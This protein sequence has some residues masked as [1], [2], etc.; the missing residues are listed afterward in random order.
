MF[1]LESDENGTIIVLQMAIRIR[2]QV[3][4]RLS[5]LVLV[6]IIN[7]LQ[8]HQFSDLVFPLITVFGII[9]F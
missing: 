9:K 5:A 2:V 7:R 6:K 1:R 3:V 8:I 4:E